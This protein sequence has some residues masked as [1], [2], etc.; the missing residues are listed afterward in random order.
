MLRLN[1]NISCECNCDVLAH[2]QSEAHALLVELAV[3]LDLGE[4]L[5]Q[6]RLL[7]LAHPD[8]CVLH[9]H[10]HHF[11]LAVSHYAH[12]HITLDS[13]LDRIREQVNDDLLD[14][15]AISLH[16]CEVVWAGDQ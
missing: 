4:R 13:V 8:A 2:G 10:L 5:E 1:S 3:A 6:P 12:P 14:T 9:L 11:G 16:G 7:Q 15:I